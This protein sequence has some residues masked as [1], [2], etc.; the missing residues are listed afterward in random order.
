MTKNNREALILKGALL[1]KQPIVKINNLSKSFNGTAALKNVNMT[2]R[3]G[4]IHGLLGL[5]GAGKS[6]LIKILSG[7]LKPDEGEI[8]LNGKK[9]IF[10]NPLAAKKAGIVT[11]HQNIP[12]EQSITV[13]EYMYM[14]T[15]IINRGEFRFCSFSGMSKRCESIF[16]PLKIDIDPRAS[17]RSLSMGQRQLMHIAI[18][19]AL[20]P[21]VLLLDEPY[22][23]LTPVEAEKL[24]QLFQSMRDEGIAIVMVTHEMN[25]AINNCDEISILKDGHLSEFLN[26]KATREELIDAITDK[27]KEYTYPYIK[28][29]LKRDVLNVED[30]NTRRLKEI[31]FNLRKGEILGVAGL[32]GSG[33]TSL[34]QALFGIYPSMSGTIR[35]NGNAVKIKSPADAIKNKV[36]LLPED[37]MNQGIIEGFSLKKNIS[38]AN[39]KEVSR[40]KLI[41]YVKERNIANKFIKKYVIKTKSAYEPTGN[42]SAG[43]KQKVSISKWIFSDSAVLIMD[44]PTQ[45]VDISS[46]VEIYNFMNKY[47]L[48]GGSILFISSD[49]DELMGMSDRIMLMRGGKIL[50]ILNR[51]DF[52]NDRIIKTLSS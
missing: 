19:T 6:T 5:N 11:I 8:L 42:L 39:L 10:K 13:A 48:E 9:M 27:N 41:R 52:S 16:A 14:N 32:L 43:N 36:C 49:F 28:R 12:L 37:I 21:K 18:S 30:L 35:V 45:C 24:A 4:S 25:D 46:K 29:K 44:D 22:S 20:H 51:K 31:N 34:A 17:V 50:E 26:I 2:I 15:S 47:C 1:M 7:M 3:A 40:F 38:L 33:K 23:M